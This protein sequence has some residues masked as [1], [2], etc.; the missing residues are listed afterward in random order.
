MANVGRRALTRPLFSSLPF[1]LNANKPE[2]GVGWG[3]GE[4]RTPRWDSSLPPPSQASGCLGTPRAPG[5]GSAPK[6]LAG[7]LE[8][9]FGFV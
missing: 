3:L 1:S 8:L 6:G 4:C 7:A 9:S 5:A 2:L